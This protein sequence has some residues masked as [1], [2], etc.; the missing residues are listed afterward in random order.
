LMI[1]LGLTLVFLVSR[2]NNLRALF[3]F[4]LIAGLLILVNTTNFAHVFSRYNESLYYPLV[5][6][7]IVAF[8]FEVYDAVKGKW[9]TILLA[10]CCLLVFFR[11]SKIHANGNYL[12][13]RLLQMDEIVRQAHEIH[14]GKCIVK[15]DNAEKERWNLNWSY[16]MESMLLSATA[17][18]DSTVSL[19]ADEDYDNRDTTV[20]LTEDRTIIRRWEITENEKVRPFFIF[21]NE[22]YFSFNSIDTVTP[23]E[24]YTGKINLEFTEIEPGFFYDRIFFSVTLSNSSGKPLSSL[25]LEKCF[26]ETSCEHN[27]EV[28]KSQIPLDI[29]LYSK[30]TQ[31]LSCPVE[32]GSGEFNVTTKLFRNG[33]EIKSALYTFNR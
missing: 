10:C 8:A 2:K 21:R 4:S 18:P 15:I 19:I 29:D 3:L 31:I 24:F 12:S 32:K 26:L 23:N 30:Y 9:K 33:V 11:V 1:V 14:H 17:G 22:N 16:P 27:G 5:S 7:T 25:P 20:Q 13:L 6:V 28:S